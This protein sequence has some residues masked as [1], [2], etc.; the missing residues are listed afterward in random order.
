MRD[1]REGEADA[2][3]HPTGDLASGRS[4][5]EA[6][7]TGSR[8]VVGGWGARAAT[9]GVLLGLAILVFTALAVALYAPAEED[10]FIYYRYALN[11]AHGLGLVWNP[12]EPVEGYS[13]PVWM[14]LIGALARLGLPLPAAVPA[15]GIGCGAATVSGTW[16]LARRM[17]LERFGC[18]ASALGLALSYPFVLW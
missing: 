10:A 8:P 5:G 11:W 13:S 16:L 17:G 12:G 9:D 4:G 1:P 14:A 18:L 2:D 3:G 6:R 7:A 15:L